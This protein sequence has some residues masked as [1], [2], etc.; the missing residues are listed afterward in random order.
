MKRSA[1]REHVNGGGDDAHT[2]RR[3]QLIEPANLG[4]GVSTNNAPDP[5]DYDSK[6]LGR[7]YEPLDAHCADGH[8][9]SALPGR[10]GTT[11]NVVYHSSKMMVVRRSNNGMKYG[12]A[13]QEHRDS[14]S[15][16]KLIIDSH[17]ILT[18]SNPNPK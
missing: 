14:L 9:L 17:V 11:Y 8:Y 16:G 6:D 13:A 18:I 1:S 15:D 4:R 7:Q 5:K 3:V 12:S 2:Q 10:V